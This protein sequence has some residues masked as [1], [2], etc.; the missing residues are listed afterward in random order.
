MNYSPPK[1]QIVFSPDLTTKMD[2]QKLLIPQGNEKGTPELNSGENN[3]HF[4]VID[5][6]D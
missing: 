1:N 2:N 3:K 5:L 4:K 6:R